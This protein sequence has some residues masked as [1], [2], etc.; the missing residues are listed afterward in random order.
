MK[1]LFL[2]SLLFIA[3]TLNALGVNVLIVG[4]GGREHALAHTIAQS[5]YVSKIYVAPGNGGTQQMTNVSNVPIKPTAI[6][7]LVQFAQQEK[8]DV[9]IVG[10]EAPLALGIVDTF[11]QAGLICV[12][13]TQAAAQLETSKQFA[14]DFMK[15]H[16]IPT[17]E[18]HAVTTLEDAKNYIDSHDVPIVVKADGLA[19][20]KGVVIAT[21]KQ[22][23]RHAAE[24]ML[25]GNAFGDAGRTV[26][27]EQFLEG[28][29]VSFFVLCDGKHGVP[30]ATAQDYKRAADKDRGP[31]TGGMG[32]Y[33]PAPCVTAELHTRIMKEIIEPTLAG[34]AKE[35]NPFVGFLYAGLMITPNGDPYVIEFNCRL[36][37]PEAQVILP[38]LQTDF[39]EMCD[40][41]IKK[42]LHL[43]PIAWDGRKAVAVVIA[44]S[45]YPQKTHPG[46]IITAQPSRKSTLYHGATALQDGKLITTGG[47]VLAATGLANTFMQARIYAYNAVQK[48]RFAHMRYRTDIAIRVSKE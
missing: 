14:K 23:A 42:Q 3:P 33:S 1:T 45:G 12:G 34:M 11:T 37:D 2:F 38:R 26:V 31:N 7:E 40:A 43:K 5:P 29:E 9:T 27:F 41:L 44:D 4:S 18:Y 17:A 6:N 28:Q 46:Q 13:P 25:N 20:G 36:G 30:F 48:V 22:E 16:K 19:A 21:T 35:G 47:R 15:R 39:M 32:A 10:P 24:Q 8:I